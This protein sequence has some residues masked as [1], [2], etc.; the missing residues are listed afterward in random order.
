[1]Q[2]DE[3]AQTFLSAHLK[4]FLPNTQLAYRSDLRLFQ[5]A[6]P[7]LD[8]RG[9]T[10]QHLRAF[11]QDTAD[12]APSTVARRQATLRSCFR[13]AYQQDLIVADPTAKLEPITVPERE[14]RPLTEDQVEAIL[15]AIPA[16]DKRNRLLFVLLYETG[17]RVGE[18][19]G[20]LL[21]HIA[22]NDVDGGAIRVVGKGQKERIVPLIDAPRTVRLLRELLKRLG[23]IG[24]LF[25]GDQKKGGHPAE[26][27]DRTTVFYHFERYLAAARERQMEV[28]VGEEAPITIHRF[29]HTYATLKLRDGVSLSSLRK[30]MGHKN[31][32]TTLRYAD[33]D[34]QTI[35]QEL[36][37]ARRRRR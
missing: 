33:S 5:R 18:A 14:P 16:A 30:L 21:S 13:W 27:L 12:L 23:P 29:R 7:D 1:M 22:L 28:F 4:T 3:L 10:I 31:L 19:L 6:F 9:I 32:Q 25:R 17:M 34:L 15:A 11:L 8:I 24:P 36:V 26:A 20:I 37:E 2:I 35:K